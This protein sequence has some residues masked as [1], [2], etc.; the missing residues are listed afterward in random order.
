MLSQ[1][2]S[3]RLPLRDKSVHLMVCSPPYFGLR[4]YDGLEPQV[5][6]GVAE[7]RHEWRQEDSLIKTGRNDSTRRSRHGS[8]ENGGNPV[9][10]TL[11]WGSTGQFCR[12][13]GAWRGH[14]GNENRLDLYIAH[15]I[16]IGREVWRCLRDDG[17]WF[18]N[19][20][21]SYTNDTK[22]GGQ[23]CG[24]N[25]TS[26]AGGYAGQ[27]IGRQT[28]LPPKSQ[29]LIPHRVALALQAEGWIVRQTLP[30]FKANGLPES[31]DDRPTSSHEYVFML[32]KSESYYWDTEA[33]KRVAIA[34]YRGSSFTNGK[35]MAGRQFLSAVGQ[36]ERKNQDGANGRRY[37]TSDAWLD[38][39]DEA[40]ADLRVR[41][42]HLESIRAVGGLLESEDGPVAVYTSLKGYSGAHFAVFPVALALD[43]VR[44]ATSEAGRCPICGAPWERVIEKVKGESP[45]SH[46]GSTFTHGK[47]HDAMVGLSA[48]GQGQRTVEI[49]TIGWQPTCTCPPHQPV[50]AIVA[51]V[52]CGSGTVGEACRKLGRRFIGVDL[53]AEYLAKYA[54]PRAEGLT[55][56]AALEEARLTRW[57]ADKS[58][59]KLVKAG[60]LSF[61]G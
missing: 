37:R 35:T 15:L 8:F 51:D 7:C 45:A 14:L 54:A 23:S 1:A 17:T 53:S 11:R 48:V 47:T 58:R 19:L 40:I 25:Y 38:S 42:D 44:G 10:A 56:E 22:W 59:A 30:W 49:K 18:L 60:Q 46:N 9:G 29:L 27:R 4:L 36:K 34:G 16:E 31:V 55:T 43:L 52:F 26:L 32:T 61:E 28:G 5:W 13:C 12:L 50:P 24:K 41:L 2:N 33:T 57:P 3:L 21:D 39:L 6:G 20:G